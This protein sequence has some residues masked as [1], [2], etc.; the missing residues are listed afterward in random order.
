VGLVDRGIL[1]EDYRRGGVRLFKQLKQRKEKIP[2]PKA[3]M[4]I[5]GKKLRGRGRPFPPRRRCGLIIHYRGEPNNR[6]GQ[7]MGSVPPGGED[8]RTREWCRDALRV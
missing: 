1:Q 2:A 5:E 6:E 4:L 3:V 7:E 8:C